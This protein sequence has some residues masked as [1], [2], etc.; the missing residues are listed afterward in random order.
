MSFAAVMSAIG[1]SCGR[2]LS[3][4]KNITRVVFWWVLG[5]KKYQ[6]KKFCALAQDL[7]FLKITDYGILP[8]LEQF[9]ANPN[10]DA[11]WGKVVDRALENVAKLKELEAFAKRFR[12]KFYFGFHT[13]L[14]D[15]IDH[16]INEKRADV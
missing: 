4:S 6:Q 12:G 11:N 8:L 14:P 3:N 5:G 9:A 16:V 2:M 7:G 1:G 13:D 15:L 10:D